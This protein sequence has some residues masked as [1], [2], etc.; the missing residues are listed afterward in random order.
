MTAA[1]CDPPMERF[2]AVARA[3]AGKLKG[4]FKTE[5]CTLFCVC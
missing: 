2:S 4:F 3:A 1:V 5:V